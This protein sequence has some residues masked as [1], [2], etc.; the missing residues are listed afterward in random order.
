M[1]SRARTGL[2]LAMGVQRLV[3]LRVSAR[4][5]RS[6]GAADQASRSTYPL[7]VATH[8]ALFAVCMWPRPKRR[9]P[10]L[11]E[12]A[13]LMGLGA[14]A[15][16]RLWVIRTLGD[17]WNVTAHVRPAIHI[18]TGGPYR[19]IR[20]PNYVAVALEFASLPV[21]VGA[22]PEGA[23]LSL[24]NAA[25]LVPRIRAEERL[26]DAIPG[27]REAFRGVPRF[28][29]RAGRRSRQMPASESQSL[30]VSAANV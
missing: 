6:I 2:V 9:V 11:L 21:A 16:L 20:H 3:E 17:D 22:A 8:V 14:S 13:A 19:F 26:L 30:G 29:P 10:R 7:M 1:T 27:Y 5:R 12:I 28:V 4:N 15:G 18:E 24:A 23:L 25:V